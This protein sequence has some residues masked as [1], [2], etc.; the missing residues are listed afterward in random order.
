MSFILMSFFYGGPGL[1]SYLNCYLLLYPLSDYYE[2]L[3]Q[4]RKNKTI[5]IF[6]KYFTW[7]SFY[8][9]RILPY[10]CYFLIS[11]RFLL[12]RLP[13]KVTHKSSYYLI[14]HYGLFFLKPLVQILPY[15]LV[16]IFI[17]SPTL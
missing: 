15:L 3:N 16:L 8:K 9:V 4:R 14:L 7:I 1:K 6:P 13:T 5:H 10:N 12:N 17:F 11:I 2:I